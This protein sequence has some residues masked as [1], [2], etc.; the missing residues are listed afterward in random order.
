MK[1]GKNEVT[2]CYGTKE[3]FHGPLTTT[4]HF[5]DDSRHHR[6][7]VHLPSVRE[8]AWQPDLRQI[9]IHEHDNHAHAVRMLCRQ[10]TAFCIGAGMDTGWQQGGQLG[11]R[12]DHQLRR[13]GRFPHHQ[14]E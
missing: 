9:T 14:H 4:A 11:S 6:Q 5:I 8:D 3:V 10:V 2:L 13:K 7:I 1:N 12:P